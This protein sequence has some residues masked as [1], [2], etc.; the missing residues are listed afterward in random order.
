MGG[1]PAVV[2]D[3]VGS[4]PLVAGGCPVVVG[5]CSVVVGECPVVVDV[6]SGVAGGFLVVSAVL[7]GD[8]DA[9]DAGC[10]G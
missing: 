4:C 8:R 1:C 3:K 7:D 2:G 5:S 10:P 9:V 6:C